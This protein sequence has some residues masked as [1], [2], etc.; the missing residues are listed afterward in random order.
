MGA[1]AASSQEVTNATLLIEIRHLGEK[2]DQHL[3]DDKE[4]QVDHEKRLRELEQHSAVY[5]YFMGAWN[6]LNTLSIALMAVLG[7]KP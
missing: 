4:V 5:Q 2:I 3:K 7:L 6:G 1:T